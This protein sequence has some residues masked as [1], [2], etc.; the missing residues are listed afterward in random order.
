MVKDCLSCGRENPDDLAYCNHCGA[1]LESKPSENVRSGPKI[2]T[3]C[4]A[5]NPPYASF[6]LNCAKDLV[7]IPAGAAAARYCGWC[8]APALADAR[9]CG[10]CGHDPAGPSTSHAEIEQPQRSSKPLI[11]GVLMIGAGV[12][13]I[14]SGVRTLTTDVS[15]AAGIPSEFVSSIQGMLQF[16]GVLSL[17]FGLIVGAGAIFAF[18]RRYHVLAL[19]AAIFGML[20]VGLF[21]LGSVFS[22][23]ALVLLAVSADDFED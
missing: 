21:S 3:H 4:G 17:V 5:A 7:Q 18:R 22:I 19:V 9:F 2:C 12:L 6:C 8:G 15:S 14:A 20:G 23:I 11:A 1:R 16:C 13:E 10:R